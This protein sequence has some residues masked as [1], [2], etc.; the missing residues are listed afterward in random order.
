MTSPARRARTTPDPAVADPHRWITLI[1]ASVATLMVVLDVSIVNIALPQAQSDLGMS[2]SNRQWMITAYALAFGGLLL[3]GGRIADFVGRKKALLIGLL[4]F[5]A[6]SML[7][8][9]APNPGTLFSARALQG[10][11]AALL[12]P[13]ALSLITVAFTDPKERAKAFGIF[14]AFQAGGGAVGLLLGG[15]LTEYAGWRWC[16]YINIP[17]ALP[18]ALAARPYIRESRAEGDRHYD[19]PGALLVTGG[20]VALVDGFA[21]A[22]DGDGWTAPATLVLLAAAVVLLTVFVMVEHRSTHPLLPLR[23]VLDRSRAGVFLANLLIGAGMFGMN[24]FMTYF[25][26]VNLNYTPLQAGCAFLPFS[27]GII[28]TTTLGAPLVTRFGPKTLMAAGTT[29]ATVGLLWLTRL[30]SASGYTGE[31]LP[32][33]TLVSIGVG[34]FFLAGPNVALSA[35]KPHDAGVASAALSTSQQIGAALGPALL[36]TLYISA[37]TGYLASHTVAPGEGPQTVRLEAFL[38]GYRIAF[39]VAGALLAA[40]LIALLALVRTPKTNPGAMPA[41]SP[42]TEAPPPRSSE[43]ETPR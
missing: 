36:N 25:L 16:M 19:I 5:A 4:G 22:A 21:Q 24:L 35:V 38:H 1:V 13:A 17:I 32:T 6:A 29:L 41:S 18:A 26:Q 27:V 15:V 34:F 9:L 12:A 3:I 39:I 28:A 20:L 8:G 33:Q 23:V 7:G 40:A 31:V 42:S 2:D 11:F 30:D 14:G 43:G 10:G 37:V